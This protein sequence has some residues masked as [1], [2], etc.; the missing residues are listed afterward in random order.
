MSARSR[1]PTPVFLLERSHSHATSFRSGS[2]SLILVRGAPLSVKAEPGR[3]CWPYRTGGFLLATNSSPTG[4]TVWPFDG[5]LFQLDEPES[6]T[7]ERGTLH[8]L[9]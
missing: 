5:Q 6:A 2:G 9:T 1:H 7:L 8:P 3:V 4:D